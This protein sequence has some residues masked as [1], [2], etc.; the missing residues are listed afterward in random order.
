MKHLETSAEGALAA[1]L[2]RGP[3]CPPIE[4]LVEL[5]T[6][7]MPAEAAESIRAHVA[8]CPACAAELDLARA[9]QSPESSVEAEDLRWVVAQLEAGAVSTPEPARILPMR[10]RSAFAGWGLRAAA[11]ALVAVALG[12]GWTLIG[13]RK[14]PGLPTAGAED[15]VRSGHV[16][17]VAPLDAE[18]KGPIR[19][20]WEPVSGA[21]SYRV[22]LA[23]V[24]D[25]PIWEGESPRAGL[26]LP[27]VAEKRL[28]SLVTYRWSVIAR[29]RSGLRLAQSEIGEFRYAGRAIN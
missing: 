13:D 1:A 3:G 15:V 11:A 19:F 24:S 20:S 12:L 18:V 22:V 8:G 25:E 5:A 9:F 4:K 16:A 17:L 26:E 21:S 7:P 2:E 10:R 14:S 28:E 29:D 23:D 27:E 6:R